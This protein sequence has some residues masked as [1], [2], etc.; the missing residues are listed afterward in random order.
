M[1]TPSTPNLRIRGIIV[2]IDITIEQKVYIKDYVTTF[3]S[4]LVGSSFADTISGFRKYA[5]ENSFI[6]YFL[7]NEINKNVDGYRL[8]TFMYKDRDSKDGKLH[9]G[10]VWDNNLAWHNANYCSGD[11]STGWAYQFPCQDDYWQ[12]PFWWNRLLQDPLFASR[13]KCRWLQLRTTTLNNEYF[14]SYIDSIANLLN[15]SQVRNFSTWPILGVYVWPNPWPYPAT[16]S[17]EISSLKSWISDRLTWLDANMP[18]NCKS[19]SINELSNTLPEIN[20]YPNPVKLSLS[21]QSQLSARGKFRIEL[22]S[23]SGSNVLKLDCGTR[24]AGVYTDQVNL[25]AFSPGIYL[26]R[27]TIN[28]AVINRKVI[29]L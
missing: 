11:L 2:S 19:N 3:E 23:P 16:Y 21:V 15:E 24:D 25:E 27:L 10:P 29:K 14:N 9:M 13:L 26:L 1:L 5:D 22:F 8:S 12:V 7:I 20:I 17:G 18:G 4:T 6:D 28:G